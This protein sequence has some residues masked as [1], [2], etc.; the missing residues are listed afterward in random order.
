[1]PAMSK[2][3]SEPTTVIPRFNGDRSQCN[4]F[5]HTLKVQLEGM[6]MQED[7]DWERKGKTHGQV[8][9]KFGYVDILFKDINLETCYPDQDG[10]EHPEL[11][12]ARKELKRKTNKLNVMLRTL[13]P[14]NYWN[15]L[16]TGYQSV[17]TPCQQW[18]HIVAHYGSSNMATVVK[19]VVDFFAKVN[20]DFTS[21]DKYLAGIKVLANELNSKTEQ[22]LGDGAVMI[23]QPL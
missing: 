23:S 13:I 12:S 4:L 15:Q 20:Q 3:V 7:L 8:E 14:P 10:F 16:P 19:L 9:P 11:A 18:N 6:T 2:T 21:L 17:N 22:C 5:A 1:M